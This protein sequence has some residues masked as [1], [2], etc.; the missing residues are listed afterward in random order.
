MTGKISRH[1][2][3]LR[4]WITT[5]LGHERTSAITAREMTAWRDHLAAAGRHAKNGSNMI[6]RL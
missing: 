2:E 1:L 3:R 4:A 5:G 6:M